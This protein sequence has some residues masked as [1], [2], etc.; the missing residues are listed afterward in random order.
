MARD[1]DW[2]DMTY[3]ELASYIATRL[4]ALPDARAAAWRWAQDDGTFSQRWVQVTARR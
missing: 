3:R 1:T 2:A 4:D